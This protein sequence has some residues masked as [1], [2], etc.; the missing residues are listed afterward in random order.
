[1]PDKKFDCIV[2]D[3]VLEHLGD[4]FATVWFSKT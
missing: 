4:P 2:F 1:M 3:D